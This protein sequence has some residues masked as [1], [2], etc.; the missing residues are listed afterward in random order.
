MTLC[1]LM[2]N[3]IIHQKK[4]KKKFY[5]LVNGMEIDKLSLIHFRNTIINIHAFAKRLKKFAPLTQ[6]EWPQVRQELN[7]I[8]NKL[9]G[10]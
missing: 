7:N 8:K 4:K 6:L 3:H 1:V 9:C 2:Y 10:F 5:P